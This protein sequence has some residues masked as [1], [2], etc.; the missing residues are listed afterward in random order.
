MAQKGKFRRRLNSR[1]FA[2]ALGQGHEA[3]FGGT[4]IVRER[5][6][7]AVVGQLPDDEG[8]PTDDTG[9]HEYGAG[10]SISIPT[11]LT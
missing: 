10:I 11:D 5:T 9:R 3:A 4:G 8:G 1:S 2:T 6:D 7:E